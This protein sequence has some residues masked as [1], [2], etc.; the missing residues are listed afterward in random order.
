MDDEQG[1]IDHTR[2]KKFY[3]L[4]HLRALAIILVLLFHYQIF[5]HHTPW[6]EKAGKFGWTGVDL[7]FVLSGY[8]IASQLFAAM[9]KGKQIS[10]PDFFIKRFFR[11]IPA[12]LVVVA[13]YFCIQPFREREGLSPLWRFLTFT[14]NFHLDLRVY[15]TFSHSW[16][17]C[18]EEQFYLLLPLILIT[19]VYLKKTSQGYIILIVLFLAGFACR[20]FTWYH[21]LVPLEGT[22]DYWIAWN[23][24]IYYPT[25]NRLDGLLT[26][27]A[28]AAL[29]QFKPKIKAWI[30]DRAN[31]FLLAGVGLL[32]CSYFVCIHE[33]DFIAS[34]FGFPL[35]SVSY[36]FIVTAAI[37]PHTFLYR[38]RSKITTNLA[39]LSYSIY[40]THKGVIHVAQ[41]LL[42]KTGIAGEST[43][44]FILCITVAILAA[45][46]MNRIVEKPFLKLREVILKR[47][48]NQEVSHH[49]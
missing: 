21:Y 48:R 33:H 12:Y 13:V 28:I 27:V 46:L 4:D 45:W 49:P 16:S 5:D 40:L 25:Y 30:T 20:V 29:F 43:L 44:M 7:F 8:L 19:L 32:S 14:Q 35:V 39:T 9:A 15:G 24:L 10:F 36:G 3:G 47:N 37:S 42:M 11:I 41:Q 26:G 22:D 38:L 6:I 23:E 2:H 34:V 31:W 17:L 18:I 1:L